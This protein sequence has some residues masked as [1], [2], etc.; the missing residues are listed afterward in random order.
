MINRLINRFCASD[1]RYWN[2]SRFPALLCTKSLQWFSK[3]L[4]WF[5]KSY[6][7]FTACFKLYQEPDLLNR[8]HDLLNREPD[9][10]NHQPDL[11]NREPVFLNR[12]PYFLNQEPDFLNRCPDFLKRKMI[13]N[14]GELVT[15]AAALS[16]YLYIVRPPHVINYWTRAQSLLVPNKCD[17]LD[18]RPGSRDA[19][20]AKHLLSTSNACY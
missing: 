14:W 8:Q 13:T 5:N 7:K 11:L 3:P 6:V 19:A 2:S 10:L 17:N 9:L 4:L 16:V 20:V 18:R 15:T 12:E 1:Y